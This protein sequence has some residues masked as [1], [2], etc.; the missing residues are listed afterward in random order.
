MEAQKL[1][2]ANYATPDAQLESKV[3][4]VLEHLAKLS[5]AALAVT[6]KAIYAWDSMHFEKGL[7][8]AEKVYLAELLPTEDAREGIAAFL[9]K[10]APHWKGK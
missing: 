1:G 3:G 6:K 5:P 7:A 4:I 8:R 9:A 2:L 10:R